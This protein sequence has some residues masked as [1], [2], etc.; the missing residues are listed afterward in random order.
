MRGNEGW[1]LS[2][3]TSLLPKDT[4]QHR[5]IFGGVI[6]SYLDIAGAIE[7]KRLCRQEVVTIAMREVVFRKPVFVGDLVSFYT[8][9][10]H[11]GRTSMTVEVKVIAYRDKMPSEEEIHVTRAS[12]TYVAI[13]QDRNPAPI[14]FRTS[15]IDPPAF[16]AD[17]LAEKLKNEG[18]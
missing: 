1:N 2:I 11:T 3:R 4:N 14:K 7:A 10:T 12:I 17:Y 16:S 9:I 5:T 15:E 13:D 6:L 8:R 18:D